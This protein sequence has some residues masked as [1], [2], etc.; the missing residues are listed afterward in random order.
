[1]QFTNDIGVAANKAKLITKT[2]FM[3]LKVVQFHRCYYLWK[4]RQ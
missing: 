1:V 2:R 4:V 3:H